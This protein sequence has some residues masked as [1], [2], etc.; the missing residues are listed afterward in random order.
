MAGM[1]FYQQQETSPGG[2]NDPTGPPTNLQ[3][4]SWQDRSVLLEGYT[5]CRPIVLH[6]LNVRARIAQS[7]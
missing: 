3:A 6:I 5:L 4:T 7:I 2:R 1:R